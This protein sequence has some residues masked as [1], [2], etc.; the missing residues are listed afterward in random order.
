MI[1][2]N[3]VTNI[4]FKLIKRWP[5]LFHLLKP[6]LLSINLFSYYAETTAAD[7]VGLKDCGKL[8]LKFLLFIQAFVWHRL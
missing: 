1:I 2:P 8:F 6:R 4:R 3:L 7:C 5:D